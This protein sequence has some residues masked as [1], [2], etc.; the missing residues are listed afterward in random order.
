MGEELGK[1]TGGFG[2]EKLVSLGEGGNWWVWVGEELDK[3]TGG[4][5]GEE[6]GTGG[7]GG[8]R[9][10]VGLGKGPPHALATGLPTPTVFL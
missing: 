9:K 8:G 10:L 1:E 3:E 5:G 2:G 6:L 7:F 4:F